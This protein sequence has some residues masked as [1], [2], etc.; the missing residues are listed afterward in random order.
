MQFYL[1]Q[2]GVLSIHRNGTWVAE[3]IDIEGHGS[4]TLLQAEGGNGDVSQ[5]SMG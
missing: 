2:Q 3:D 1:A 5:D 4:E